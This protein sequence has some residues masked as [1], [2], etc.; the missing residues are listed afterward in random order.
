LDREIRAGANKMIRTV[1]A[2]C[3]LALWISVAAGQ[4]DPVS[5]RKSL[6]KGNLEGA[7]NIVKMVRGQNSFDLEQV[8]A[9]FEQWTDTAKKLPNLFPEPPAQG[10]KTRA[11]PAIWEN[12]ADFEAKIAAFAKAVSESRDKAKT[13]DELKIAFPPVNDACVDCHELYRRPQ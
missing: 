11:L 4:S 2:M 8:T 1:L 10:T 7:R 12:K 6:M 5:E 3:T 13:L 9:A